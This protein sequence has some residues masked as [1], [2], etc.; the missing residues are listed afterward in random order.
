MPRANRSVPARARHKKVIDAAKGFRGRRKNVYRIAK[1]A[2]MKAGHLSAAGLDVFEY[3]PDVHPG[4][5]D[6]DKVTLA[7]HIGAATAQCHTAIG[8]CAIENI[9]AQFEGRELVSC[10]NPH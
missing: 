5:L 9:L 7:P 4:L 3:E 2:V 1:Q 8:I 10:V 6:M